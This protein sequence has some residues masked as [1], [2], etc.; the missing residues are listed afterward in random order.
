MGFD[1]RGKQMDRTTLKARNGNVKLVLTGDLLFC[2]LDNK[3][4]RF[5][6]SEF[7]G[8]VEVADRN[9]GKVLPDLR[10]PTQ[11]YA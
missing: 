4:V 11:V 9:T 1:T 7:D 10:H 5:V 6:K 8:M 3:F 2:T